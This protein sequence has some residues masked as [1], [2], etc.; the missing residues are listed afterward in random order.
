MTNVSNGCWVRPARKAPRQ[1][2]EFAIPP[3]TQTMLRSWAAAPADWRTYGVDATCH[4][5]DPDIGRLTIPNNRFCTVL[6]VNNC[7][8]G[9]YLEHVLAEQRVLNSVSWQNSQRAGKV[10]KPPIR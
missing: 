1:V 5:I 3:R 4:D 2:T 9:S 10:G 8:L 6:M 7:L